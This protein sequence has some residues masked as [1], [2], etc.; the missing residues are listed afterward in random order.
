MQAAETASQLRVPPAARPNGVI[1]SGSQTG[2][3]VSGVAVQAERRPGVLDRAVGEQQHRRDRTDLGS[4]ASSSSVL[5]PAAV[6]DLGVVVEKHEKRRLRV[7]RAAALL[8]AAKLNGRSSRMTRTRGFRAS[9]AIELLGLWLDRAV[10]DE[11]H[12]ETVVFGTRQ[13]RLH[14]S[15]G[16]PCPIAEAHDDLNGRL[17]GQRPPDTA[18]AGVG[19]DRGTGLPRLK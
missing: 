12:S 19:L 17:A 9:S 15:S 6:D 2:E 11:R 16:E 18:K 14:A 7:V 4:S 3:R 8:S 5:Q 10:V 1:A 13:Q